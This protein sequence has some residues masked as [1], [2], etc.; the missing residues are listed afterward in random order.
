MPLINCKV[1]LKLKWSKHCVL[2][3]DGADNVN[4]NNDDNNII[5]S[6]KDTKLYV[7]MVPLSTRDNQKPSKLLSKGFEVSVYSNEYK[8]KSDNKITTNA[9][10]FFLDSDFVRVNRLFVLVIQMKMLLLKD[11]K[12]KGITYQKKLLI[13]IM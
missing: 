8:T 1:E 2:S 10:R 5:F 3:V 7:P 13:I 4:G 12:L 9:F 11:L 6:I